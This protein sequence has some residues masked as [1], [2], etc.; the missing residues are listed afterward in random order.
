MSSARLPLFAR[1]AVLAA[2]VVVLIYALVF[3]ALLLDGQSV[4]A[5][6]ALFQVTVQA[7]GIGLLSGSI[8][9]VVK[10]LW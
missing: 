8:A 4:S 5:T 7:P 9:W 3:A 1:F 2:G 10:R 6:S